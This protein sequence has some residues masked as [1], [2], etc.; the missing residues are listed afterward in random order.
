MAEK[1]L[2]IAVQITPEH[3]PTRLQLVRALIQMGR[4]KDA[5]E[6]IFVVLQHNARNQE[7][8][9]LLEVNREITLGKRNPNIER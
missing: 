2:K 3:A 5:E 6:H 9:E 4:A 7:A 8:L 1:F